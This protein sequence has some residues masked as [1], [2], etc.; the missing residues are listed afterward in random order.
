MKYYIICVMVILSFKA[1]SQKAS[2]IDSIKITPIAWVHTNAVIMDGGWTVYEDSY[3]GSKIV[4]NV[5][6]VRGA[7]VLT[8]DQM[9]QLRALLKS[10]TKNKP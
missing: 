5:A 6:P 4:D 8:E 10:P 9:K 3:V 7:Y 2:F 1:H